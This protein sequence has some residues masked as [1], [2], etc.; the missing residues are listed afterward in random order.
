M[1]PSAG[2]VHSATCFGVAGCVS[3]SA[4]QSPRRACTGEVHSRRSIL[5]SLAAETK[6][7]RYSERSRPPGQRSADLPAEKWRRRR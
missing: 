2:L 3:L 4:R 5:T 1:R 6:R 7:L